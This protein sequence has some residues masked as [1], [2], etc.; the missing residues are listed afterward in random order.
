VHLPKSPESVMKIRFELSGSDGDGDLRSLYLW[1][2]D[3]RDLRGQVRIEPEGERARPGEMGAAF[4]AV[5]A[6]MSAGAAVGQLALAVAAWREARRPR[7]TITIVV[8]DGDRD[9]A[10]PVDRALED[11]EDTA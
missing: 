1:L 10:G 7:S 6:V 9:A 3:D 2:R 5:I 4:D 11:P 8:S